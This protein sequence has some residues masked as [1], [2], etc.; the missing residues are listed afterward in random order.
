M[1]ACSLFE[2]IMESLNSWNVEPNMNRKI[3][4]LAILLGTCLFQSTEGQTLRRFQRNQLRSQ[5][6]LVQRQQY[7]VQTRQY[8]VQPLQYQVQPRQYQV[9]PQQFS[10]YA[11]QPQVRYG[12]TPVY[13]APPAQTF[14][15]SASL[16]T[17]LPTQP[18]VTSYTNRAV[19][20]RTQSGCI[21]YYQYRTPVY[22]SPAQ[23]LPTQQPV[24]GVARQIPTT[25]NTNPGSVVIGQ[26]SA[27]SEST[28]EVSSKPVSILLRPEDEKSVLVE[29]VLVEP[30]EKSPEEVFSFFQTAG[31]VRTAEGAKDPQEDTEA[32]VP[33]VPELAPSVLPSDQFDEIIP[34]DE[35]DIPDEVFSEDPSS[36]TP[37]GFVDPIIK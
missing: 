11:T 14:Q 19:A 30:E 18:L 15:N 25:L 7:Q 26:T 35:N 29:P 3:T 13:Q 28:E 20:V 8:Q 37:S 31:S 10:R 33:T 9:Q 27:T 17:Q 6:Y 22:G 4:L 1:R 2:L 12:Q 34:L 16:Q 36:S 24:T 32:L 21:R 5:Q 23:F